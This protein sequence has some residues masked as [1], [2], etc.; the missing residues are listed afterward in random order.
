LQYRDDI[1]GMRAVAVILIVFYHL[2]LTNVPGGFVGVDVFFVISG[3]LITNLIIR[4]YEKDRF[5]FRDFYMRRL[6][7]LGPALFVTLVLTLTAGWFILPPALYQSTAHAALATIFSVSN[8]LFWQ[9]TGYFD[10]SAAYKPLLHT[11]SLG[12]EEQFYLIWPAALLLALRYL[13]RTGIIVALIVASIASLALSEALLA[14]HGSAAFYLTPFRIIG[15]GAGALLAFTGWQARNTISANAASAGGLLIIFYVAGRYSE[16]TSFPGL[17]SAF[18]ALAAAMMIYAGP[19]AVMNRVLA[20]APISYVGRISYSVY[21]L[22]WPIIVYGIFLFGQAQTSGELLIMIGLTV[23]S[24][25]LLYHAIETP[26]RRKWNGEFLVSGKRLG[27][28]SLTAAL[29]IC[30]LS[31]AVTTERGFPDRYAPEIRALLAELDR[32]IDDRTEATGE[33]TCNATENSQEIYFAIFADC[34]PDQTERMI[35]V[36]GDSHA[37]DVFMGLQAAYPHHSFVQLTGNGCNLTNPTSETEFCAPFVKYWQ[38]WLHDHSRQLDAVIYTQSG[39]SLITKGIG[40]AERPDVGKIESLLRTLAQF[41][42]PDVPLFFWGP[43]VGFEPTIDVAIAGSD[44][45]EDLR[46]F[47][48]ED[49]FDADFALDALL[50]DTLARRPV[51]YV[52]S[53]T[54][55]CRPHCP[56]LT[57][58]DD[59]YIVDYGHWSLAGARQAVQTV[60]GSHPGL[61]ARIGSSAQSLNN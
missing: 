30:I 41:H 22:H 50:Q 56:T 32:A 21:L 3:F 34:L 10:T 36:L 18:P 48:H 29:T 9:E 59:L 2:R 28:G 1:D 27:W 43:R 15:F 46:T 33:F 44:D 38:T 7:R 55:L 5:S 39:G 12:V 19:T 52:S 37:A 20:L 16:A 31:L 58:Q 42:P 24:G 14:N 51:H 53:V 11:W 35:V 54:A 45:L 49:R 57:D 40:G 4:D 61:A 47:Y 6:R 23:A 13:N 60:I 25:A 8:I 26:F 17:N